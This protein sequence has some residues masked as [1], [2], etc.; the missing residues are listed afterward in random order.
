[1]KRIWIPVKGKFSG[2]L[3]QGGLLS[4]REEGRA[5]QWDLDAGDSESHWDLP[6]C[7]HSNFVPSQSMPKLLCKRP[8]KSMNA[9]WVITVQPTG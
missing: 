6:K 4:N 2:S 3:A 9:I 5:A 7:P 8:G 1:M